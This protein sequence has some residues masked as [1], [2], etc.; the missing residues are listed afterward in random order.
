MKLQTSVLLL[1]CVV[2]ASAIAQWDSGSGAART[3]SGWTKSGSTVYLTSSSDSVGIGTSSPNY[4]LHLTG[5]G[6]IQLVENTSGNVFIGLASPITKDSNIKFYRN[7]GGTLTERWRIG[8]ISGGGSTPPFE[9]YNSTNNIQALGVTLGGTV[10]IK[11]NSGTVTGDE[12]IYAGGQVLI[13]R[14]AV[15]EDITND[16]VVKYNTTKSSM[17][18]GD[19]NFTA[20]SD[21]AKKENFTPL[22]ALLHP[23]WKQRLLDASSDVFEFNFKE[24]SLIV[25]FRPEFVPG[26]DTLSA[27]QKLAARNKYLT[28]QRAAA[29]EMAKKK[30][31]RPNAQAF[32]RLFTPGTVDNKTISGDD[33]LAFL[34]H[35]TRELMKENQQLRADVN[36]LQQLHGLR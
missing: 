32:A 24:D 21:S 6:L 25:P 8:F 18:A 31:R 33:M 30:F 4:P 20:T 13:S 12:A 16:L 36:Q 27:A 26:Y 23:S 9:I 5:S 1:L 11:A 2:Y 17:D 29:R 7:D 14:T 34:W 28:K 3:S 15:Y 19:I 10:T 35:V 22:S